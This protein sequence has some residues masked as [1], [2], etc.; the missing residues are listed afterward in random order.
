MN[1]AIKLRHSLSRLSRIQNRELDPRTLQVKV[2]TNIK[3]P[4]NAI[5][6]RPLQRKILRKRLVQRLTKTGPY[7]E[8][9]AQKEWDYIGLL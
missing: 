6:V 9:G 1:Q 3:Q 2:L 8:E 4:R 7:Q 5:P